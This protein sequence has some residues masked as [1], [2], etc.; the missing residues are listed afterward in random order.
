MFALKFLEKSMFGLAEE[1]YLRVKAKLDE[2]QSTYPHHSSDELLVM[3]VN[4]LWID[5]METGKEEPT[6]EDWRQV[7][8]DLGYRPGTDED[9]RR[10][11]QKLFQS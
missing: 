8:A 3:A 7:C 11:T 10:A 5:L 2:I 4:R 9:I 1:D 6:I